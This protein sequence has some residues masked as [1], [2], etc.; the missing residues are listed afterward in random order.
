MTLGA[1][2]NSALR[3]QR[4]SQAQ[5]RIGAGKAWQDRD[6]IFA[7]EIGTPIDAGNFVARIHY[8]LPAAAG[9]PRVR[10]HDLRHTAATLLLEAGAHPRV[11]AERL[12]HA[13]PSLVMNIY[14][15]A[16]DRM[17][18]NTTAPLELVLGA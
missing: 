2:A 15:H 7:T 13:T 4:G 11:V 16:T 17:Q 5:E 9:L 1:S 14:G 12:G 18:K 8:P 6:L 10:F 3:H